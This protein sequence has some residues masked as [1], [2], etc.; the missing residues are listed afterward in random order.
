MPAIR[1]ARI[2][3]PV[4]H[5]LLTRDPSVAIRC[6]TGHHCAHPD[7]VVVHVLPADVTRPLCDRA[8]DTDETHDRCAARW[9]EEQ[10]TTRRCASSGAGGA[11]T[12]HFPSVC[13]IHTPRGTYCPPF[14]A[15]RGCRF[16]LSDLAASVSSHSP[17]I[18]WAEVVINELSVSQYGSSQPNP[19]LRVSS[20]AA[21]RS[22]PGS[23]DTSCK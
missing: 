6:L 18:R 17:R 22:D 4:Y 23:G 1:T 3:Q 13:A 12:T 20:A 11:N 9:V 15:A 8:I 7:S 2:I 5:P 10:G 14:G 16:R 19:R 21:A